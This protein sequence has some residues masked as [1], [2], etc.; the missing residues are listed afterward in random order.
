MAVHDNIGDM[1]TKLRNASNAGH[2]KVNYRYS[3]MKHAI[4]QILVEQ[5]FLEK[6]ELV[7]SDNKKEIS[8][9]V[10]YY[11]SKPVLSG[12]K[13]ISKPGRRVYRGFDDIPRYMNG[14][15]VTIVSTSKGILTGKQAKDSSAGGEVVCYVW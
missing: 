9:V 11:N 12:L 6:C 7:G 4:T 13:R 10:R 8:A 1:L 3:K 2:K 15:A 14:L 5:G